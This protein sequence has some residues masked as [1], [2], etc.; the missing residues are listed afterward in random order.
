MKKVPETIELDENDI[1]DAINYWLQ[2]LHSNDT[3]VYYEVEFKIGEVDL[4]TAKATKLN[5][6]E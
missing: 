3:K 5:D 4:I 6:E 2:K 1:V